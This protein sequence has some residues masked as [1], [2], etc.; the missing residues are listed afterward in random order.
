MTL[1]EPVLAVA[2][3]HV[4]A[5]TDARMLRRRLVLALTP[6]NVHVR[7]CSSRGGAD[8]MRELAIWSRARLRVS[9]ARDASRIAVAVTTPAGDRIDLDA[10]GHAETDVFVAL[11]AHRISA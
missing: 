2:P 7:A 9:V 4:T 8:V 3:F 5:T 1:A 11:I 6:T 10:A